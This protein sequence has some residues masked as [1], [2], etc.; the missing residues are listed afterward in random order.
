VLTLRF[1]MR[2]ERAFVGGERDGG[3]WMEV[4]GVEV[5]GC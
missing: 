5:K 1:W 3:W 4:E 2:E